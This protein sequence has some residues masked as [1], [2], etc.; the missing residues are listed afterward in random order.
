M[1]K[2]RD[3]A[4]L[5]KNANDRLDTVATSD[6][7]LSNRNLIING[8]MQVAQRG[9][10]FSASNG[11]DRYG[12]DRF[13]ARLNDIDQA[14]I[15][16]SQETDAPSGFV[17]SLKV[18]T[19]VAETALAAD[20]QYKLEHRVEGNSTSQLAWGTADAKTVTISFWFKSSTTG[21]TAVALLNSA[22][23]RSYIASFT[24]DAANTWEYKTLTVAGP[25]DGTWK[26]DNTTGIRFRWGTF[27]TDYENTPNQ[28]NNTQ[29]MMVA[30]GID[31][32]DTVDKYF[33][34]TGVQLEVGDTAT[35]FE[36]RSY[37][38]ELSRCER[39]FQ[40]YPEETTVSGAC[41]N[42]D[43]DWY[44]PFV[45]P[46]MRAAPTVTFSH[47]PTIFCNNSNNALTS[48]TSSTSN[49]NVRS[50]RLQAFNVQVS[51]TGG[52]AGWFQNGAVGS[53]FSLEAEL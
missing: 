28:W 50:V 4:D 7:A 33:Q 32:T 51:S 23:D 30:G 26:T 46:E 38:D 41:Y 19:D 15:T 1:S 44:F 43:P 10:S 9:T 17:Y 40:L 35:P 21:T 48:V 36:H 22:N 12:A 6:G 42:D 2:A 45:F 13:F 11:Q 20:E 52:Q 47:P 5:A 34:I 14:T 39:Y 24:V 49:D 31:Y 29:S 53:Y 18:N 16:V 25:T 3:L 27:G 8:A 37:A